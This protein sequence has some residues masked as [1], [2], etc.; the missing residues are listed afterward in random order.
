MVDSVILSQPAI[1]KVFT[2]HIYYIRTG[3]V[4]MPA[5]ITATVSMCLT[6]PG[7]PPRGPGP[8]EGGPNA[9]TEQE[10]TKYVWVVMV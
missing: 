8:R 1:F 5:V 3:R 10:V 9:L 2:S 4:L 6:L 7:A